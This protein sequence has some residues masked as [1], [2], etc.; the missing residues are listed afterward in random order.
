MYKKILFH[1]ALISVFILLNINQKTKAQTAD[2]LKILQDSTN[3]ATNDTIDIESE[4]KDDKKIESPINYEATD[5]ILF[6]VQKKKVYLYGDAMVDYGDINLKAGY[7]EFDMQ[8]KIVLA[9][10]ITDTS[11]TITEKPIFKDKDKEYEAGEIVYNFDTKKGIVK[12][13]FTEEGEGYLHSEI[14][15]RHSDEQVHLCHGKYTTCSHKKPHFYFELTKA[16]VIPNDKIVSG[17]L[18]LVIEG[19]PTPIWLPFAYIPNQKSYHSGVVIP[20]F[21]ENN[22]KGFFLERGGFYWKFNDY[23]DFTLLGSISS[24]KDWGLG[25]ETKYKK[26]YSYTGNLKLDYDVL[27]QG[28]EELPDYSQTNKFWVTWRHQQDAKAHPYRSFNANVSLGTSDYYTNK[29][30]PSYDQIVKNSYSS[31]INYNR[32]WA[33]L[34]LH[35]NVSATHS[36]NTQNK[37]VNMTLPQIGFSVD[38]ISPF[39]RE[40]PTGERKWYEQLKFSYDLDANHKINAGDSTIFTKDQKVDMGAM[41]SVPFNFSQKFFKFFRWGLTLNNKGYLNDKHLKK[42]WIEEKKTRDGITV[43]T[44][45]IKNDTIQEWTY[46]HDI[47]PSTNINFSMPVYFMYNYKKNNFIGKKIKAIRHTMQLNVGANYTPDRGSLNDK[48]FNEV[49]IDTSGRMQEYSIYSGF[50][51][52]GPGTSS[53]SGS[54]SF[55]LSNSVEMK[56]YDENDT[57]N[58]TRK[59]PLIKSLNFN[60]SYNMFADSLNWSPVSANMN[61]R[62]LNFFDINAGASFSMYANDTLG[63]RYDKF[64]WE[65]G[66]N[67]WLRLQNMNAS[68]G[69]TLDENV[70]KSKSEKDKAKKEKWKYS[71][72]AEFTMPWSL[73]IDYSFNMSN[74]FNREL[75]EFEKNYSNSMNFTLRIT[76]TKHWKFSCRSGY[77]FDKQD[78]TNT[79]ITISR[80]LHCF[81]MNF[82][83]SPFGRYQR[84]NFIIKVKSAMLQ[85]IKY[86]KT[87]S[88]FE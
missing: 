87:S 61:T 66:Q 56:V 74:N 21:G 64:R 72:Y 54:V 84:Y 36:Q 1:I 44:T 67:S 53:E 62:L 68:V 51:Y 70:F 30:N 27:H 42:T 12:E 55:G 49:Q 50:G 24:N 46:A 81:D 38:Q 34:P 29:V 13:V 73:D 6:D 43:D 14:T 65:E 22:T 45:Y 31:S 57:I 5:S 2:S 10:G 39:E 4:R 48:Y 32:S 58:G 76:P 33:G 80:D 19:V 11:G 69:F 20:T 23:M 26:R 52:G 88:Y 28:E 17:P 37:S 35:L 3:I 60:T 41:H 8:N 59:I 25:L 18:Y 15:K 78:I 71:N 9:E 85:D 77:D 86:T 7:I 83:W 82:T 79:N 40:N 75:Q 63:N 16:K 47:A